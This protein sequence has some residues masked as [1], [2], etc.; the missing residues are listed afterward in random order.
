MILREYLKCGGCNNTISNDD[1]L[2][3]DESVVVCPN[4]NQVMELK[5]I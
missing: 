1:H 3:N 2:Y 5:R 4:D